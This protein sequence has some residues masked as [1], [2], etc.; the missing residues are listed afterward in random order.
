MREGLLGAFSNAMGRMIMFVCLLD[1]RGRAQINNC[2]KSAFLMIYSTYRLQCEFIICNE[3]ASVTS[4]VGAV[5]E[6]SMGMNA[7]WDLR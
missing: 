4:D 1:L 6:I 2:C 3:V 5:F 7:M